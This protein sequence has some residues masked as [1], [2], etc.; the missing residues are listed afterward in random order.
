MISFVTSIGITI[1][2]I[3][4]QRQRQSKNTTTSISKKPA[5]SEYNR[6]K[7]KEKKIQQLKAANKRLGAHHQ[8]LQSFRPKLFVPSNTSTSVYDLS[9]SS[10][11]QKKE[12]YDQLCHDISIRESNFNDKKSSH[13]HRDWLDLPTTFPYQD[14]ASNEMKTEINEAIAHELTTMNVSK[15][16]ADDPFQLLLILDAPNFGTT[17]TILSHCTIISPHQIIIPQADVAHYFQMIGD[18]K[19]N[20]NEETQHYKRPYVNVRCQ[21]LDHWLCAN[22]TVG[23]Q[24]VLAY[25]DYECTFLGNGDA[26]VSPLLDI[27]RW[28][29]FQYPS[30]NGGQSCLMVLTIKFRGTHVSNNVHVIDSFIEVEAELNGYLAKRIQTYSKS[31]TTLLYQID[32]KAIP[33]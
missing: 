6:G 15:R 25:F 11:K 22:A 31:L 13:R 33:R 19:G 32:Q 27:Q 14:A 7:N 26:R 20:T 12:H 4:R 30:V 8:R 9:T 23:F 21:R 28:F 10:R 3:K 16:L 2:L 29:R 24:H 5:A 1:L 17:N 18:I